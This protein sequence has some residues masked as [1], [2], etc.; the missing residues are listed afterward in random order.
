MGTDSQAS[1]AA[2]SVVCSACGEPNGPNHQCKNP[3]GKLLG[4]V[5]D[6]RYKVEKILGQGGMGVV[7]QA[8][9]TSMKRDVALKMLHPTLNTTPLFAERFRR[10]AE[11]VSRLKHPNIISIFD[12][13]QTVEGYHYYTMEM[14]EGENLKAMVKR[15]GPMTLRRAVDMIEQVGSALEYAH[16]QSI[17]HRDMKP[18]NVMCARFHGKDHLKVLDFGLVK[19]VDEEGE[20]EE[21]LTT[22]GQILGTPAYMS[23][24]QAAG[25]KLDGRSDLYSLGV[26]FYFLL[27]GSTPYKANSATKLLAMAMGNEIPPLAERRKGAPIPE[28]IEQFIHRALAYDRDERPENVTAFLSELSEALEGVDAAVLDAVPEGAIVPATEAKT[29][30][31]KKSG[32]TSASKVSSGPKGNVVV[33]GSQ[34]GPAPEPVAPPPAPASGTKTA[35]IGLAGVVGVLVLAAVGWVVTHPA[36]NEVSPP[37]VVAPKELPKPIEAPKPVL[38]EVVDIKVSSEP[39]GAE[40][41]DGAT[42][43]GIAPASFKVPRS[44]GAMNLTFKL[45]GYQSKTESVDITGALVADVKATLATDPA[46]AKVPNAN[47]NPTGTTP[48]KTTGGNGGNGGNGGKTDIPVFE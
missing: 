41:Y 21:N 39:A 25:D 10:E 40:V 43:L 7:F 1:S 3:F 19:M 36:K 32:N 4:T 24:E 15:D 30:F 33:R 47:P 26:V 31:S 46:A 44:R 23:P 2:N 11:V 12:F 42:L 27:A 6:G 45:A 14:L 48:K 20:G 38:S 17:L 18:H 34:V 35:I 37:L 8:T 16:G 9:Q 5:V 22:T 13:G 29:G 28:A